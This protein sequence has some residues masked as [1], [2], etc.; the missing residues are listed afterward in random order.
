MQ[1]GWKVMAGT[2]KTPI[3]R[4]VSNIEFIWTKT[5]CTQLFEMKFHRGG[6]ECKESQS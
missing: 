1:W 3:H 6:N 4:V 2:L 5:F